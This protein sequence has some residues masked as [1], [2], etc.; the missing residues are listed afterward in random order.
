MSGSHCPCLS[1]ALPLRLCS[2]PESSPPFSSSMPLLE[3]CPG[4]GQ[5]VSYPPLCLE[6]ELQCLAFGVRAAAEPISLNEEL[7]V[8]Q[9]SLLR[10][11]KRNCLFSISHK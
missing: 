7:N 1:R 10:Y 5:S 8:L 11:Y 6:W 9:D 3:D 2:A 4:Q